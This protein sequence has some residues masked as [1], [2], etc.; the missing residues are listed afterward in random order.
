MEK[1]TALGPDDVRLT[2][3]PDERVSSDADPGRRRVLALDLHRIRRNP[4]IFVR[5]MPLFGEFRPMPHAVSELR[6]ADLLLV[7]PLRYRHVDGHI[8]FDRQSR[9]SLDRHLN[10]FD[11]LILALPL[12]DEADLDKPSILVWDLAD[13]L[14][15]RVQFVP[16]PSGSVLD[17]LK[18]YRETAKTLRRCID[19]AD[20]LL[21][22]I[23]GAGGLHQDWGQ[24]AAEEAIKAGRR[25]ALHADW[26][27]FGVW[28]TEADRATGLAASPR[29]MKLRLKGWLTRQWQSRLVSRC[30]LMI[31]NGLD[32]K[33]AYTPFC[34]SP[35]LAYK[36]NDFQIGPDKFVSPEQVEAKC[37]DALAS[38][39][40]R[41]VYA[42][43]VAPMKGPIHWVQAIQ[44]VEKLGL[45]EVISLPG[46]VSDRDE[47][48]DAIRGGD[49]FMFAHLDP[50]SPRV[51]IESL[52]SA[53]PIVG[54]LRNHPKDL[55][56][57]NEGGIMT[58]LGEPKA[59]GA[60]I[61]ELAH[62]RQRLVD[63]I[64]RAALDG[65]RFDSDRMDLARCSK[66]KEMIQPAKA[67]QPA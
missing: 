35:E 3:D 39:V 28:K 57:E 31:C 34:R 51:L 13:D 49:V 52:I 59:L 2:V 60:T 66:I 33:M 43:R 5:W 37:R 47:V 67:P 20:R 12:F 32:T 19:S 23:G 14:L 64:R 24:V 63:L 7:L 27:S 29:R 8:Y 11:S 10:S 65:A 15:D 41:V 36:I 62:D 26:N 61:A 40:L 38:P 17:F 4:S 54:Y 30:D 46:F 22:A 6:R 44:E 9:A 1:E 18:D 21:F 45:G 53:T 56:S 25:F 16:L 42:G 48:I 55:I 50:E 58:P